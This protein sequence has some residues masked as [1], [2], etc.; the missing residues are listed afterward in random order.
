MTQGEQKNNA[1]VRYI[2]KMIILREII[3]MGAGEKQP[4]WEAV[5]E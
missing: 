5:C 2:Q 4:Q 1:R 3:E